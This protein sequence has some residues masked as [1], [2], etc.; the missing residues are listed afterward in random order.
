MLD[1][2]SLYLLGKTPGVTSLIASDKTGNVIADYLVKVTHPISLIK[3]AI[4]DVYPDIDLQLA[5]LDKALLVKG[6]VP[7]PE[8]IREPDKRLN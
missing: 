2:N 8:M 5:S 1:D 6:K 7:S 4:A 3:K